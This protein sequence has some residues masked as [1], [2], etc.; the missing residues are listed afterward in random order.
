MNIDNLQELLDAVIAGDN[1]RDDWWYELFGDNW[2][3]AQGSFHGSL[4]AA[5][6]LHDAVLPWC[7][8]YIIETDP[9][10]LRVSVAWWPNG[11]SGGGCV[12]GEGWSEENPARA[13][14][15]A[16]IKALIAQEKGKS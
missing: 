7:N 10:C 3:K 9:T 5:K 12:Q 11:L 2:T 15:I 8:Q 1:E 16:I 13:W 14:L 6:A 4:D